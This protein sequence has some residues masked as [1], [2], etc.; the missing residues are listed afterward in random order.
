MD[1]FHLASSDWMLQT[2]RRN[3]VYCKAIVQVLTM[4][5]RCIDRPEMRNSYGQSSHMVAIKTRHTWR[6]G[7][8][9]QHV[10]IDY[11]KHWAER[12]GWTTFGCSPYPDHATRWQKMGWTQPYKGQCGFQLPN[13]LCTCFCSAEILCLW[14]NSQLLGPSQDGSEKWQ[15]HPLHFYWTF[16]SIFVHFF[17][18]LLTNWED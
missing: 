16:V 14:Q 3:L 13:F 6:R 4:E 10:C 7:E 12:A 11:D 17:L 18:S 5:W 2:Q 9:F 8:G 1:G 15:S